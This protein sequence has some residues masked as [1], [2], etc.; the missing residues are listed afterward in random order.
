[1][2]CVCGTHIEVDIEWNGHINSVIFINADGVEI[3]S[4]PG[5]GTSATEWLE[6]GQ[7]GY[8]YK[9]GALVDEVFEPQGTPMSKDLAENNEVAELRDTVSQLLARIEALESQVER[10]QSASELQE[11]VR[12]YGAG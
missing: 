7:D 3:E 11:S 5:C 8:V 9:E 6:M 2:K 4:C 12:I 10:L 1:M